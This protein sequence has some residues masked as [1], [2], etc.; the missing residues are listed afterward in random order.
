[1]QGVERKKMREKVKKRN[2]TGEKSL[3]EIYK[4][5]HLNLL[6]L[7][8]GGWGFFI[9][10]ISLTSSKKQASLFNLILAEVSK[11]AQPQLFARSAPSLYST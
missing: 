7:L 10:R 1:V 9:L 5:V 6:E 2:E 3:F 4:M 8:V 11:K